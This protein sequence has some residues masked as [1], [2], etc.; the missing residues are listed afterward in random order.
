[1]A[2]RFA[3]QSSAE[4]ITKS[5]YRDESLHYRKWYKTARWQQLRMEVLTRDLFTC[6]MCTRS[7][8]RTNLLVCDHIKPHRGHDA[9]FWDMNNLQCLCKPCHDKHKQKEEQDSLH[10]R[11]V[12]D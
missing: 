3:T 2:S 9:L 5:R 11:G 7:E 12:W 1:M 6:Q 8:Y 10:M 4:A